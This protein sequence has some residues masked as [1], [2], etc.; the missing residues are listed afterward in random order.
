MALAFGLPHE[1]VTTTIARGGL[2]GGDDLNNVYTVTPEKPTYAYIIDWA[3]YYAPAALYH[4]LK[5]GVFVKTSFRPFTVE[6]KGTRHT[7]VAGSLVISIADQN[8]PA[9]EVHQI[10][11]DVAS[12]GWVP[13]SGVASGLTIEG[14][15]L[16]SG[17]IRTV[18]MPKTAM[19]VGDGVSATEAGFAWFQMDSKLNMPVT[20]VNTTQFNN[21]KLNDYTTLIMVSG[22]YN[23]LGEAGA[24][25][26][27]AWMQQGGNLIL[28]KT[29]INWAI[30]NKVIEEQLKK[31]DEKKD[32]VR[33]DFADERDYH[34]SRAIGG[35]IFMSD[36]DITHPL[37]FGYTTRSVPVWRN[38]AIF[39]EPSKNS[40]NTVAKMTANPL[41]SGYVHQANLNK[42]KN[43]PS[44]MVSYVGRG[45]AILFVDDPNFR[46]YWYG[47]SKMFFNAIFF[48]SQLGATNFDAEH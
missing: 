43:S 23:T 40:V 9:T 48:G 4:L 28:V 39:L 14:T 30:Q 34:G 27:K 16:G 21:F 45:Q 46:G 18:A 26:V 31:E 25:K 2:V 11:A 1:P 41:L 15:N 29:A 6:A 22:G 37:G 47:T 7:F 5:N 33:M 36:L 13:V 3:E 24:N 32:A 17:S 12:T 38:H 8:L 19:L 20:K 44:L 35:S 42:I 10:I